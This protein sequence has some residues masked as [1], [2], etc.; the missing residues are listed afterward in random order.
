MNARCIR[1]A[2]LSESNRKC[3]LYSEGWFDIQSEIPFGCQL[4]IQKTHNVIDDAGNGK[5]NGD[6]CADPTEGK[7]MLAIWFTPTRHDGREAL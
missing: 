4:E 1:L 5:P 2:V 6:N 7:S 3:S